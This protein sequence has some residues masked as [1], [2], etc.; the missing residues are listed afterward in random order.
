MDN[1]SD[2]SWFS[3]SKTVIDRNNVGVSWSTI[4][5]TRVAGGETSPIAGEMITSSIRWTA[6]FWTVS[7]TDADG[8][9]K[10]SMSPARRGRFGGAV[11]AE[12]E[13]EVLSKT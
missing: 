13:D 11:I 6:I 1:Y 10:F 2:M 8:G 5:C 7:T 9:W 12:S 4:S 3:A